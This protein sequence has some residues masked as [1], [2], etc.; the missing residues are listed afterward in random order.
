MATLAPTRLAAVT[1]SGTECTTANSIH[2]SRRAGEI[3]VK[4]H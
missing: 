3:D 2:L 1:G 4:G